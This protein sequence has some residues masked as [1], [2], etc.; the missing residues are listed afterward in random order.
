MVSYQRSWTGFPQNWS[1]LKHSRC[2]RLWITYFIIYSVLTSTAMLGIKQ[3]YIS[4]TNKAMKIKQTPWPESAREL[5]RTSERRLSVKVVPTFYG[6]RTWRA[7]RDWSLRPYSRF[8][9]PE[10]LLFFQVAPQ[11]YSRAWVDSVPD[12]LLYR[13]S[14]SAENRSRT[15]RSVARI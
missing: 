6:Q 14:G 12:P 4:F 13:K 9:R 15:S 7:Q 3:F 11:L 2:R 10:P 8:S 5:Y 1:P